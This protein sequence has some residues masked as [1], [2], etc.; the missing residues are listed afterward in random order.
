MTTT[1]ESLI[2]VHGTYVPTQALPDE[3]TMIITFI[4]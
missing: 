1:T 3:L 4:R 2:S